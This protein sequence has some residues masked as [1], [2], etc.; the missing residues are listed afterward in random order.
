MAKQSKARSAAGGVA[1]QLPTDRLAKEMEILVGALGQRAVSSLGSRIDGLADQLNEYARNGGGGASAKAAS[2]GVKK[3]AQGKSPARA[4]ASAGMTGLGAKV[5]QALRPG[6]G[7]ADD[8]GGGDG[9]GEKPKVT[10]IV[11]EIDVGVPVRVAYGQWTRFEEFPSFTKKV[12]SVD[13]ESDERVTWKAQVLWSHRSWE[14]KIIEQVPDERIVWRSQGEKG[15]V[16]GAVTFH[17]IA[18]NLTRILLV[19]EYHPQGLFERTGNLWRAQGRRARLELKHFQRHVMTQAL[20]HPD[21]I[22]GW[23]GEIRDGRVVDSGEDS[24]DGSDEDDSRPDAEYEDDYDENDEYEEENG[25]VDEEEDDED[26]EDDEEE[27]EF[28]DEDDE[29][30]DEEEDEDDDKDDDKDDE[31]DDGED[32]D[33][34]A[35]QATARRRRSRPTR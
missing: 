26:G 29:E 8:S 18:P 10:N 23:R 22:Q 2:A 17:E 31:E 21:E 6:G 11:E 12:E 32:D 5:K 27:D 35:R 15:H 20:L 1:G 28:D 16:D 3:I 14:A 30:E 9:A 25:E 13:Q 33:E 7:D 24:E 4:V 19:L 34:P